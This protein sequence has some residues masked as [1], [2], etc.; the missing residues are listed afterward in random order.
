MT[1]TSF[2]VKA[3]VTTPQ[4]LHTV[5]QAAAMLAVSPR[6]LE[7]LIGRGE[8]MS[9]KVGRCR[10]VPHSALTASHRAGARRAGGRRLR[11][12]AGPSP[13]AGPPGGGRSAEQKKRH[14][15]C[16]CCGVEGGRPC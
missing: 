14:S 10:R 1:R 15:P 6:T 7:K 2:D 4:L 8:L 9:V 5:D 13:A 11:A 16:S 12:A 3:Q